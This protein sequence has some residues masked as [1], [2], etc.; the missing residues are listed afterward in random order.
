[1]SEKE[2]DIIAAA[3][4][5]G[6]MA[7]FSCLPLSFCGHVGDFS[8]RVAYF[9]LSKKRQIAYWNIR[10]AL[11]SRLSESQR[12]K[13]LL[14]QFRHLGRN[15]TE[16]LTFQKL[17]ADEIKNSIAIHGL[18]RFEKVVASGKGAVLI[19]GHYGNWELLQVVAGIRGTPVHVLGRDQ[20]HP[21]LN[22]ILM[23]QRESHGSVAVSRGMNIRFLLKALKDGKLVGVLGDQSAGRDGGVLLPFF[24]RVTTIPTGSFELARRMGAYVLPCFMTRDH[25]GKHSI[26]VEE[27]LAAAGA[28]DAEVIRNQTIGYLH[29][30][31]KYIEKSPQQW[32][33]QNKRWKYSWTRRV[34][35]LSDKKPGHFKQTQAVAALFQKI[36]SYHGRS[37]LTF[38]THTIEIEYQ[39]EFRARILKAFGWLLS[40]I[41][42]GRLSLL[43]WFLKQESVNVLMNTQADFILAAGSLT[44]PIQHLFAAETGA[45]K[46]VLMK[47][48]F[49]YSLFNYDLAIIPAHDEGAVP[50]HHFR[51]LISPSG[52]M[53]GQ[54]DEE[55]AQ[56]AV[57]ISGAEKP[58]AAVFVGGQAHDYDLTVADAEKLLSVLERSTAGRGGFLLTTSRRTSIGVERFLQAQFVLPRSAQPA[59][60]K[61]IIAN[62]DTRSFAAKGMLGLAQKIIVTED[63]LAMISEAVASGKPVIV[64]RTAS[65]RLPEKHRR[66]LEQLISKGWVSVAGW[67]DL[68]Q[69]LQEE[70]ISTSSEALRQEKEALVQALQKLL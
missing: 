24:G 25:E 50:R 2:K 14:A 57:E 65:D 56:L 23:R 19:T 22:E 47:P 32:L 18:E 49:P 67:H 36:D 33:W 58:L 63:S 15:F 1:V 7:I 61:L 11:G 41:I 8:G 10:S 52:Y 51:T 45:K 13:A 40:P 6:L 27:P 53:A 31:E 68:S 35:I 55:A 3:G 21:K 66:F 46:I 17:T 26:Y 64:L 69:R 54:C 70:N 48:S 37:G 43:K 12:R 5:R 20:R 39:S 34:V 44:A 42:R 38:E 4:L 60:R 30:L 29:L 16:V 59:F 62:Q 28:D 9:L